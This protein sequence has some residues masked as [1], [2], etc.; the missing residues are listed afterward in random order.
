M[1]S[2]DNTYTGGGFGSPTNDPA[3]RRKSGDEGS[4]TSVPVMTKGDEFPAGRT[5]SA[6]SGTGVNRDDFDPSFRPTVVEQ[7]K[8][9]PRNARESGG[10]Y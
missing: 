2:N 7:P 4:L 1:A 10:G 8:P 5:P 3:E 9:K 6:D